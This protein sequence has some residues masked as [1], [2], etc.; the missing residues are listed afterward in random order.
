MI[1]CH[2]IRN[3]QERDRLQQELRLWGDSDFELDIVPSQYPCY[4]FICKT[5]PNDYN[6]VEWH[7]LDQSDIAS[8]ADTL[9][10]S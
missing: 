5:Y 2:L 9:G 7:I 10:R 8:M 6:R 4:V 1:E 3:P